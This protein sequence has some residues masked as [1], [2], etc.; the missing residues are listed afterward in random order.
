MLQ[1]KNMTEEKRGG[2]G[3]DDRTH[4][5]RDDIKTTRRSI[6]HSG[7]SSSFFRVYPKLLVFGYPPFSIT[8]WRT[9]TS[10]IC[11]ASISRTDFRLTKEEND[12]IGS[13]V[14]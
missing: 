6:R 14:L 8:V 2:Q 9:Q 5:L 4:H 1:A 11:R 7:R 3:C 10:A 12:P 13:A